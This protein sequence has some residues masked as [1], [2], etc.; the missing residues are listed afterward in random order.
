[1]RACSSSIHARPH[2][3][4]RISSTF[5][6][7][8]LSRR[9]DARDATARRGGV[10][11]GAGP[12]RVEIDAP[13]AAAKDR[14][15]RPTV[16]TPARRIRRPAEDPLPAL[17]RR[18]EGRARG[19]GAGRSPRSSASMMRARSRLI[20]TR[21]RADRRQGRHLLR[22]PGPRPGA[23]RTS[24]RP[25]VAR[26]IGEASERSR[27]LRPT[28][29]PLPLGDRRPAMDSVASALGAGLPEE[30]WARR[31]PARAPVVVEEEHVAA[32][33]AHPSARLTRLAAS[34]CAFQRGRSAS[35]LLHDVDQVRV[36]FT[37]SADS[38]DPRRASTPAG[39]RRGGHLAGPSFPRRDCARAPERYDEVGV[40][41]CRAP[42]RRAAQ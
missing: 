7:A 9:P 3:R 10:A 8:G 26:S 20:P 11:H 39:A 37:R 6:C 19:S 12:R 21:L 35:Q 18:E 24:A 2:S 15:A 42:P 13:V 30:E 34:R 29:R 16:A 38:C 28:W 1:M 31:R 5:L 27:R 32:F 40:G 22:G 17:R 25:P 23:L 36:K 41:G 33:D 14:G 4:A